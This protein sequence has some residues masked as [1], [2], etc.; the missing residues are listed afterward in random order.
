MANSHCKGVRRVVGLRYFVKFQHNSHHFLHLLFFSPTVAYNCLLNLKRSIFKNV[1][2]VILSR[3]S[4]NSPC[5]RHVNNRLCV[6]VVEKL[7]HTHNFIR[8]GQIDSKFGFALETGEAFEAL[9]QLSVKYREKAVDLI[10]EAI[11]IV[12]P[13]IVII[14]SLLVGLVL[15]SVMMPLLGILSD[16]AL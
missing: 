9:N 2:P 15:L 6:I 3:K 1:N 5:L 12:E 13:T 11:S 4:D 8:T 10:S 16:I 14:L 7:F